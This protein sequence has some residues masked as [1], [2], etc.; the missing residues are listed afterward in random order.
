MRVFGLERCFRRC[1]RIEM[2][3]LSPRAQHRLRL[4]KG[5]DALL[6]RGVTACEAAEV[7]GVS[8]ASLYR[9]QRRLARQGPRGLEPRSRRP[10]QLRTHEWSDQL[11]ERVLALRR[12]YPAW[13]KA[14]LVV[15]L[16]REGFET[17]ESTVGRVLTH[18]CHKH[19][20]PSATQL[21]R[22]NARAN[23][24]KRF[25]AQRLPKGLRPGVPGEIIQ[26][27]SL[28]LRLFP[29]RGKQFTAYCPVSHWT[30]GAVYSTAS[31]QRAATF[32]DKVI[33]DCPF[34]VRAIQV[35]GGSEF[36]KLFEAR[37]KALGLPLF[38]LPPK[39]PKLNGAVERANEA[40]RHE[41]YAAYDLP[42]SFNLLEPLV[43]QFQQ[44]Y[45]FTRPH[46]SLRGLTPYQ[47]LLDHHPLLL[48]SH[49]C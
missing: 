3:V 46:Q 14:K 40:W 28:H 33:R 4:L 8:K 26:I 44:I 23:A 24:A 35:D 32:L 31:S 25:H 29:L 10:K 18:L 37:C 47:Y 22:A 7:L 15:L 48:Q 12:C 27:D 16:R 21:R 30:V 13:G 1:S 20:L 39:S 19:L 36:K 11:V 38:V 5:L 2:A 42:A 34:P 17:S 43:Q 9:W 49:M 41:F 6:A 45:N